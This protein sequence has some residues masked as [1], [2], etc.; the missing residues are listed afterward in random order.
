[1]NYNLLF[2][3]VKPN[4]LIDIGANIGMFTKNILH[5]FPQCSCYLIEA[6]PYCEPFLKQINQPYKINGL[7]FEEGTS[8]LFIENINNIGTGASLY[9]ENTQFYSDGNYS[10]IEVNLTTLDKLNIFPE[11]MIDLIKIDTQ[12]SELDILNGGSK[13]IK[14]SKYVLLE[15]SL[16]EYN[17]KAPLVDKIV[18]K[19]REYSFKIEDIIDYRYFNNQIFQLDILFRNSY[20]Y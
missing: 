20:I 2:N 18:D 13:T 16:L 3:Y 7:S 19:M 15:V 1:M 5:V 10:T 8:S 6:N 14:R 11:E 12:G 17:L 9:K 4:Y